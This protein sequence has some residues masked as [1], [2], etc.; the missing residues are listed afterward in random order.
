MKKPRLTGEA[1]IPAKIRELIEKF[2]YPVDLVPDPGTFTGGG[3][4]MAHYL[5]V[6]D[7]E[8]TDVQDKADFLV[9]QSNSGVQL[10][11][12]FDAIDAAV[13][14]PCSIWMAGIFN[15]NID[16]SPPASAWIR[17]L[18]YAGAVSV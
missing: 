4:G 16:V 11:E 6:S 13:S 14:A 9:A 12:A 10:Q 1:V 15:L 8:P 5:I 2:E 18:G 3:G 17:G 7:S